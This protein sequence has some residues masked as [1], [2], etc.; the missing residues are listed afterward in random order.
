MKVL[1]SLLTLCVL[2]ASLTAFGQNDPVQLR[3]NLGEGFQVPSKNTI[4]MDMDMMGVK[5]KMRLEFD[6]VVSRLDEESTAERTVISMLMEDVVISMDVDGETLI[7]NTRTG[8]NNVPEDQTEIIAAFAMMEDMDMHMAY[9]QYGAMI[10]ITNAEEVV[11]AMLSKM[12]N[13]EGLDSATIAMMRPSLV[14]NIRSEGGMN[15]SGLSAVQ[16][17]EE[18]VEIGSSWTDDQTLSGGMLPLNLVSTYTVSDIRDGK[19][20]VDVSSQMSDAGGNPLKELFDA[21]GSFS[22]TVVID[23]ETGWV[24]ST[25]MEV[26]MSTSTELDNEGAKESEALEM[27]M[28]MRVT[29]ISQVN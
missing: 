2:A 19:V 11:D 25:T 29:S 12:K 7:Y 16:Y 9:D 4:E 3:L 14:E 10:E 1:K 13:S 24:V 28:F 27:K 15:Q 6:A 5:M 8:E 17:P 18:A 22:G 21:A 26:D 23:A 20:Y